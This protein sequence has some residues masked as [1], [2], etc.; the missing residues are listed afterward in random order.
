MKREVT[1]SES[2]LKQFCKKNNISL[3]LFFGSTVRG[4]INKNSDLDIAISFSAE[5]KL[6]YDKPLYKIL[7][8]LEA[9]LA[10]IFSIPG[11]EG[12]LKIDLVL[13]DRAPPLLKYNIAQNGE[14]FYEAEP[15]LY[16]DFAVRAMKEH[17][18][19]RKFYRFAEKNIENFLRSQ[20]N[21]DRKKVSPPEIK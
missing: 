16:A 3:L 5:D 7:A 14:L 2:A 18:D 13:I 17:N 10:E 8:P 21:N 6:G 4:Q 19:A 11:I 1:F 12:M 20:D 9:E 15:G